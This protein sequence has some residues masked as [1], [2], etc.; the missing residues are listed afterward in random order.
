VNCLGACALGPVVVLNGM[1]HHHMTPG[2]LR[3]LI[4]ATRDKEMREA[5]YDTAQ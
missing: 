2:K 1:Y 5:A 3:A 4:N